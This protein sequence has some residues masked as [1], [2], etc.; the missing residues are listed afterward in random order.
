VAEDVTPERQE[1]QDKR[2][3]LREHE[4]LNEGNWK[5]GYGERSGW[6][7]ALARARATVV[8][9]AVLAALIGAVLGG[10]EKPPGNVALHAAVGALFGLYGAGVGLVLSVCSGWW[11]WRLERAL[12]GVVGG[13]VLLAL[14][15]AVIGGVTAPAGELALYAVGGAVVGAL[16]G[17]GFGLVLSVLVFVV[18]RLHARYVLHR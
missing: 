5:R 18:R 12:A 15:G 8:G 10:L 16:Y 6:R 2:E 7:S 17:A 13:A 14:I 11:R 9:G 4:R 1:I 3:A